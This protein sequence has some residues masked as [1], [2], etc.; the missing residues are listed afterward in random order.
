MVYPLHSLLTDVTTEGTKINFP[1]SL[2][3]DEYY[4]HLVGSCD[5]LLCLAQGPYPNQAVLW[6]PSIRKFKILPS[7]NFPRQK[8]GMRAYGFGLDHLTCNYK[9]V[10][11]FKYKCDN[12]NVYKSQ[13][14]VH[15]LGTDD[16]WRLIDDFPSKTYT[17]SYLDSGK[18]VSGTINWLPP[19]DCSVTLRPIVSLDL[20]TESYQDILQ[21]DYGE[22][23]LVMVKSCSLGVLR[24]CLFILREHRTH[25]SD[26]WLMKEYGKRESWIRLLNISNS[27]NYCYVNNVLYII[28]HDQVLLEMFKGGLAV[29]DSVNGT[30]K[31]LRVDKFNDLRQPE[32]YVKSLMWPCS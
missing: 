23:E 4:T 6:N 9:V 15:T 21:P 28:D 10:A 13:V 31:T 20:G 8:F 19:I 5:G 14:K 16:S 11:I 1:L 22:E 2:N 25:S 17:S 7:P 12:S 26:I 27:I 3:N 18:S 32:I 29:Y 30:M 24:D